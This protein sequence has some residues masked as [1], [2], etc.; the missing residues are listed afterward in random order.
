[1]NHKEHYTENYFEW[2][3]TIGEFGGWANLDKFKDFIKQDF[4]VVDFGSGGGTY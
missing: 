2:Q 3:G 1:M 4:T